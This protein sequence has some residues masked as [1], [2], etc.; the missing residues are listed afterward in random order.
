MNWLLMIL[1]F[2]L[3]G[4]TTWLWSV[5]TVT[6]VIPASEYDRHLDAQYDDE[7]DALEG[8]GD[9]RDGAAGVAGGAAGAAAL[10]DR[11]RDDDHLEVDEDHGRYTER[12]DVALADDAE[13]SDGREL[14]S[15]EDDLTGADEAAGA[16]ALGD[17]DEDDAASEGEFVSTDAEVTDDDAELDTTSVAGAGAATGVAGFAAGS[18]LEDEDASELGD[19][20][21]GDDVVDPAST[22]TGAPGTT[23]GD[24]VVVEEIEDVDG[25]PVGRSAS[26]AHTEAIPMV[27]QGMTDEDVDAASADDL[28]PVDADAEYADEVDPVAPDASFL[29]DSEDVDDD[30]AVEDDAPYG[31][32]SARSAADGSGP[33]G[34]VIKGNADSGLFHTEESPGYEN[35]RAEV[36]FADEESAI[37]AG[38]RHWDRKQR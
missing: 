28:Q 2:A 35:T 20:I 37:A 18:Q 33:E 32:G 13:P 29:E 17:L 21:E 5:R 10:S 16:H 11:D 27:G 12:D 24:V 4:L 14:T 26:D 38:F 30:E 6:R 36:W 3:G 31:P 7:D 23:D 22:A 8:D 19:G 34:W 1:S 25:Q 9:T 15:D